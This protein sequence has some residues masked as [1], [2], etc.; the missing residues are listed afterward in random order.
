M[1][2]PKKSSFS[3]QTLKRAEIFIL[4]TILLFV[5]LVFLGGVIAGWEDVMGAISRISLHTMLLIIFLSLCNFALRGFRWYVFARTLNI[6]VPLRRIV[7]YY[8][9]GF[10]L[11]TTPGKVGTVLRA[12]FLN[13]NHGIKY[14]RATPM[15]LMDYFTDLVAM[16]SLILLGLIT[17]KTDKETAVILFAALL[18]GG[19]VVFTRPQILHFLIKSIYKLLGKPKKRIFAWA[20]RAVRLTKGLFALKPLT[21]TAVLS[22]IGWALE[23]AA[24][25]V[26]LAGLGNPLPFSTCVFIFCFSTLVGAATML[27]G[28]LGGAE[29]SMYGLLVA[30]G[31]APE[32]AVAATA[33]I[34]LCT[35]WFAV[36]IGFL[37]L[38]FGLATVK[39]K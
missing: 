38:P 9:S 23:C 27:P 17:L 39:K 14:S 3:L 22:I 31:V 25:Y 21:F 24:F 5:G 20:Q 7:L 12:W 29:V 15:L 35:L 36:G 10:A 4:V 19:F 32:N 8:V 30:N 1:P 13:Q 33:I 2:Q 34:R 28:G 37:T 11:I 6:A 16:V 26:L 18:V